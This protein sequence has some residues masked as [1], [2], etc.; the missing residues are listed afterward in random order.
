MA[1]GIT[2][3]MVVHWIRAMLIRCKKNVTIRVTIMPRFCERSSVN[4]SRVQVALTPERKALE[5]KLHPS[6]LEAFDCAAKK[7]D[8][9]QL[10]QD[11]KV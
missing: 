4:S 2:A 7:Q 3:R 9:C 10:V 8:D 6:L 5:S 11:G 1:Y